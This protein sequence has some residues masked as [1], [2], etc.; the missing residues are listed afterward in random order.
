V[1]K[2]TDKEDSMAKEVL[3]ARETSVYCAVADDYVAFNLCG[4]DICAE[5]VIAE[6]DAAIATNQT[7]HDPIAYLE[8]YNA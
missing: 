7:D 6:I 1:I 3:I 5:I 2:T 4:H 8:G